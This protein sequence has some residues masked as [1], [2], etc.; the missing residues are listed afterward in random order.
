MKV[1][2]IRH[3]PVDMKWNKR[4][5]SSTFDEACQAYDQADIKRTETKILDSKNRVI[6]VSNVK[7][8]QQT[9]EMLFGEMPLTR[10][11]LLNEVPVRSFC[12]TQK[13]YPMWI[14]H[15]M[16]RLQWWAGNERQTEL[17]KDTE[18]RARELI[19]LLRKQQKDC[20]LVSHGWFL[21]TLLKEFRK[22][23]FE[24][25]RSGLILIEPLERI[26]VTEKDQYCGHCAHN[27]LLTNPG[28]QIGREKAAARGI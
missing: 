24:A 10:T 20:I 16:G 18:N 25:K 5:N 13:E 9:A 11:H 1:V 3:A 14:W 12:D 26:L 22:A 15:F 7:R 4:Y 6:Y 8:T 23:G 17:R 28:C 21:R 2:L 19:D 27:C